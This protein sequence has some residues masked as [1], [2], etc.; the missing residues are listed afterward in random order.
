[1]LGVRQR[2]QKRMVDSQEV[3]LNVRVDGK[4][5]ALTIDFLPWNQFN[6]PSPYY[7]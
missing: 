5:G 3:A 2:V 1:M 6:F 7:G 4:W